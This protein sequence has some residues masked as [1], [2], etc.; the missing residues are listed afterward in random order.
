MI[1][2]GDVRAEVRSIKVDTRV[3]I[4]PP[5]MM[6]NRVQTN[7]KLIKMNSKIEQY[8]TLVYLWYTN[9]ASFSHIN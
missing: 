7:V 3:I 4:A 1:K 9:M 2:Q 5:P 6:T 8:G